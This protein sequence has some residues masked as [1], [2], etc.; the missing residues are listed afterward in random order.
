MVGVHGQGD[1]PVDDLLGGPVV[2]GRLEEKIHAIIRRAFH[3]CLVV[4]RGWFPR[5]TY[6]EGGVKGKIRQLLEGGAKWWISPEIR[7]RRFQR[8]QGLQKE[9]F[10]RVSG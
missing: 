8:R 5:Y 9:L 7:R 3:W 2:S 4:W 1:I 6:L 10:R